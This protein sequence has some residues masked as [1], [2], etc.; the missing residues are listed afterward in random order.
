MTAPIAPPETPPQGA[1]QRGP[2]ERVVNVSEIGQYIQL[3]SCARRFR[4]EVNRRRVA[5]QLPFA[6]RLFNTLDPVLQEIGREHEDTWEASLQSSGLRDLT[7]HSQRGDNDDEATWFDLRDAVAGL[8]PGDRAYGREIRVEAAIGD[9]QVRGRIDFVIVLWDGQRPRLRLVECK[10]S[11]RDRVYQRVQVAL[12]R[13]IIRELARN[14]PIT[15]GGVVLDPDDIE[16]VVARIDESTSEPQHILSLD[17]LSLDF[18]TGDLDRLLAPGGTLAGIVDTPIEEVSYQLNAKCDACV[19]SVH[20]FPE[21]A[22]LRRLELLGIDPAASRTLRNVG[23]LT[24]DDLA[25]VDLNGEAARRLRVDPT[26]GYSLEKLRVEAAARM[27]TLPGGGADPDT[28]DVMSLPRSGSGQLPPHEQHGQRLVRVYLSVNYDY[29]EN[30]IGALSAHVTTSE[31]NVHTGWIEAEDGRRSPNPD[32]RERRATEARDSDGRPVYE[33]RDLS[34]RTVIR[35][36]TGE[37]SGEYNQDTAAERE[38][39]QGFL[40]ELVEA[41]SEVAGAPSAPIHFYVWSRS[42]MTQ[43]AEGCSRAGSQLLGALRELLGCRESLEQLIFSVLQ[44]EV[45]QRYALGWTGRGLCVATSLTW[46]GQRYHWRRRIAGQVVDL[47]HE[48]TQDIFDFKTELDLNADG[49]WAT[50]RDGAVQRH[51]FE[52]RSRFYDSLTAPY[53]RAVWGTLPIPNPDRHSPALIHALA[54]YAAAGSPGY[55]THYLQARVHALRW[56]EES[57]RFKNADI[58]KPV[59]VIAELRRFNLGVADAA[60]AAID[61][62]RLDQHVKTTKWL[63][64]HLIPVGDRI[65]GGRT[66]PV[67]AVLSDGHTLTAFIAPENYGVT[68]AA[69]ESRSSFAPGSFVRLS[70]HGGTPEQG[71]TIAQLTR[72]GRTCKITALNWGTGEVTLNPIFSRGTRYTLQGY[73]A[74]DAG[75][76]FAFAT[77]DESISDFVAG[78]VDRRLTQ[79]VGGYVH[80]WFDPEDPQVPDQAPLSTEISDAVRNTVAEMQLPPM[81]RRHSPDQQAA[82]VDGLA[83]RVQLVQGPPGTGKTTTTATATLARIATRCHAG[84]VVVITAH[85]HTAVN[86]LLRRIEQ[87]SSEFLRAAAAAGLPVPRISLAK[88]HSSAVNPDDSAGGTVV[89]IPSSPSVLRIRQMT[90]GNVLVVGGT[91]NA[92]L[93]LAAELSAHAPYASRNHGFQSPLLVVD[94]ASMMVFPHFLA[95]A[96]L[97]QQ[98]GSIM[99]AGDHRQLAPIVAHDWEREDR[100]PAVV[101]QPFASAYEAVARIGERM[102]DAAVRR[103][104]LRLTF[105]LPPEVLQLI[106]EIYRQDNIDLVGEDRPLHDPGDGALHSWAR[107]WEGETGL[108]LVLHSESQS[109]QVNET[110]ALIIESILDAAPAMPESSIAVITPHRAQRSS[111]RLRLGGHAPALDII[112]TV[113]RLQGDER[114]TVIVS[115]TASDPATIGTNVGFLL[116]L[117][118]ANVAFSRTIDRLIIVCSETL[119]DHIPVELEHYQSAMLWKSLRPL[120]QKFLGE[121]RVGDHRVSIFTP[122][123][124]EILRQ[125]AANEPR[126]AAAV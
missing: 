80:E 72:A 78:H 40:L 39:L 109:K 37:W 48:F 31:F 88:V 6:E 58:N 123:P 82:I 122:R 76:Q 87:S 28:H 20:C 107:L 16:C 41:I 22:R 33:E 97:V 65:A 108:Y 8:T 47:D 19:F 45:D 34:G 68:L 89:D 36:K 7:H 98:D 17:P 69:L 70:P 42:E 102:S 2:E 113:E 44:E 51:K 38:M 30:R 75:E 55:L 66:L 15:I 18:E 4:L 112:D 43:L 105:R 118:R 14:T 5:R 32:I 27:R 61:F 79:A 62:L 84:D 120:C 46:F 95:L 49:T 57:V 1:A 121:M 11:R 71:Q 101:Y 93:K 23:V 35:F 24:L 64:D 73:A 106:A 126:T 83:T 60:H 85:T 56:I 110:E 125:L 91:T 21:S 99:L 74:G 115:A 25:H 59:L 13:S 104:H 52:I 50:R 53:W 96:S 9:W 67:R 26:F 94:E 12:Y 103:S 54:R 29:S 81:G 116:D 119:L 63:A 86:R 124:E 100:P 117:N 111:L 92:M 10:A 77:I 114:S 3:H 90:Q